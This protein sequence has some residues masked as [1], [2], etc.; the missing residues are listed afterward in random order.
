[1]SNKLKLN[2]VSTVEALTE[3]FTK[4][5]VNG[6]WEPGL[7]CKDTVFAEQ[8]GVSRNS[9]REA[10]SILAEQGL[11]RRKINRGYFVP[12][13]QEMAIRELYEARMVIELEA[14]ERL[15]MNK[16]VTPKMYE[17]MDLLSEK[18]EEDPRSSVLDV[19]F[20]FHLEMVKYLNNSKLVEIIQKIYNEI[21]IVNR[22]PYMFFPVRLIIRE[23]EEI[24]RSISNGDSV[25]ARQL[26]REHL[27]ISIERQL[28][29][30]KAKTE[31]ERQ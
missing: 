19:D 21:R 3:T 12:V 31:E 10:F 11:L 16:I 6:V 18:T 15:A 20:Q 26:L 22:Q 24:I 4:E 14:I 9:V 1:M 29:E 23:H 25:K 5:I 7:Q 27:L 17:A 28:K 13:F 2:R 30:Y 8:Y